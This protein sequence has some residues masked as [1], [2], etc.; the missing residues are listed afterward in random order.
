MGQRIAELAALMDGSGSFGSIVGRDAAG[1]GET[2]EELLE[3]RLIVGNKRIGFAVRAV[4]Q[5][6]GCAG[7][8]AMAGSH[9]KNGVLIVIADKAIDVAKQEI[10]ARCRSPVSYQSMLNVLSVKS[11]LHKRVAAQINLA[12]GKIVCRAPVL[13]DTG[14]FILR[15][16]LIEPLPRCSDNRL[17]HYSSFT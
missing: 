9:K 12:N 5:R 8:S 2:A 16:R 11:F 1:I 7:R 3:T 4:K 14:K 6:L 10:Q 17:S 13:I 15:D